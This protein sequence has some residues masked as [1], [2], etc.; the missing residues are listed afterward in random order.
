MRLLNCG[1]GSKYSTD[2]DWTNIDFVARGNEVSKVN[3]LKRF[4]YENGSFDGVFS[5]NVLEHFNR[6]QAGHFID[7]C[8]RVLKNGGTIRIVVPDLENI[9]REY[10]RILDLVREDESYADKY[11]YIS[12]ELLD[13]MT[14]REIGGEQLKF[15]EKGIETD[16]VKKRSGYT[17]GY[18][19]GGGRFARLKKTRIYDKLKTRIFMKRGEAHLWMYDSYSL[20]KLLKDHGFDDI[21]V[22]SFNESS[23]EGWSRYGVEVNDDGSE[24]KPNNVYVEGRKQ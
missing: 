2:P 18:T 5:S 11:E 13:Q 7:E 1:C 22:C 17:A 4:P 16:Y 15:W 8:A 10:L 3:L 23:I 19:P 12:I 14:R 24:Y 21:R 9:C 20:G 6:Q